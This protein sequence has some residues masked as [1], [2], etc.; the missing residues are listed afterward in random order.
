M[1]ALTDVSKRR[2]N[3]EAL[4]VSVAAKSA[5]ANARLAQDSRD[6]A[7]ALMAE[8]RAR[9]EATEIVTAVATKESTEKQSHQQQ[10]SPRRAGGDR[11][12]TVSETWDDAG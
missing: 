1:E 10:H 4:V 8:L 2:R 7:S 5:D 3:L 12:T 6:A 11:N 9:R